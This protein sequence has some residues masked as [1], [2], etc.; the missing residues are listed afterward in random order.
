MKSK[1]WDTTEGKEM[2][3]GCEE[4]GRDEN[5]GEKRFQKV[6]MRQIK[7]NMCDRMNIVVENLVSLPKEDREKVLSQYISTMPENVDGKD[8]KMAEMT[9]WWAVDKLAEE[10][11]ADREQIV[12]EAQRGH[13][14]LTRVRQGG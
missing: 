6:D 4:S 8:K 14:T 2:E 9:V 11:A 10:K 12:T 1:E 3:K 5:S 13:T 7:E